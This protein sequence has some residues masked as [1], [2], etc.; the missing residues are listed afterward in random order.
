MSE[1]F[2]LITGATSGIGKEFAKILGKSLNLVLVG[3]NRQK[4]EETKHE[5]ECIGEIKTICC[6]LS[7]PTAADFVWDECSK[8]NLNIHV[9]VNNAGVGEFGLHWQIPGS[10]IKDM[11][12]INLLALTRLCQLFGADMCG[13]KTGYILNIA[14]V[15][16]YQPVPKLASYAATKSYVLNFSEALSREM[17]SYGVVV[18]CLSPGHTN[19]N[20]FQAAGIGNKA[21]GFYGSKTRVCAKK[22]AEYGIKSLFSARLSV[23]YGFKNYCLANVNRFSP[24]SM[25]AWISQFLTKNA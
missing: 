5:L 22:V 12:N 19:T 2:A 7:S 15:G 6:D 23:I 17:K 25:T 10:K 8:N 16:A 11:I 13:E 3:R 14:S 1:Q 9:L 20:F 4:L 21:G 24:R 18:T